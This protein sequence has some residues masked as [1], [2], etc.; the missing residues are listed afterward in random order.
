[1][2]KIA[3]SFQA[4]RSLSHCGEYVLMWLPSGAKK[5]YNWPSLAGMPSGI[6]GLG[7]IVT[8]P[9]DAKM[10]TDKPRAWAPIFPVTGM[11]VGSGA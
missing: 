10:A 5:G 7:S 1:M 2:R 4:R 11:Q 9:L 6:H 3:P 8:T